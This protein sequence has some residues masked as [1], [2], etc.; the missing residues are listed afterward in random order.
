MF[1]KSTFIIQYFRNIQKT[2]EGI[3]ST[4]KTKK[5]ILKAAAE[6][7][8]KRGYKATTVRRICNRAQ[9]NVA[10]INYHYGSKE[11][12]YVATHEFVF[13]DSPLTSLG[14]KPLE[15]NDSKDWENAVYEFV[16]GLLSVITGTR[17]KERWQSLLFMSERAYPS[18]V[19]PTLMEKIFLPLEKRIDDLVAM[20][21]P[22]DATEDERVLWRMSTIA[23]CTVYAR[24]DPPWDKHLFPKKL[25]REKWLKTAARHVT[26]SITARLSYRG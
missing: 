5:R 25:D 24:R 18:K 20:A 6:E 10:A 4:Q 11:E 15:V 17:P 19:L 3:M 26:E 16:Y 8:S 23:Q 2:G 12:L 1:K 22:S 14:E 9:A 7:F 13:A 21:L